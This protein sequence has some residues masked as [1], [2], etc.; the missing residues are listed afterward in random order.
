MNLYFR[1]AVM[2]DLPEILL[3]YKA[4]VKN[5]IDSG[6]HNINVMGTMQCSQRI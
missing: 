1:K 5:M 3:L 2:E 6:C 4:V